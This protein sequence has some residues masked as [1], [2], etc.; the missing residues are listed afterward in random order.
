MDFGNLFFDVSA[1][2]S[3]LFMRSERAT[4][5]R[6]LTYITLVHSLDEILLRLVKQ[7]VYKDD[8]I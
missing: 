5:R 2:G 8:Y 4:F 6:K 1:L 3:F 7:I